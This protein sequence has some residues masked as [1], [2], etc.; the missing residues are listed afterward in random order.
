MSRKVFLISGPPGSGKSTLAKTIA[1]D[2]DK[3]IHIECDSL[4][5]MVQGGHKKPWEEGA[6]TL[7]ALM[8]DVLAAQA[9]IYLQAGFVIISDY[10]WSPQ[11]M[12]SLVNQI[13]PGNLFYPIFLLPK[14]S[15]N[16]ERD[17]NR[18]YTVGSERVSKY[19]ED[20]EKW[21]SK[22]SKMFFDNSTISAIEMSANLIKGKGYNYQE[23]EALFNL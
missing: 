23:I 19:W 1:Q 16:L 7:I 2:F 5:N 18:E 3:S 10:V 12:F 15:I 17:L 20:F 21:Q 8:Y 14:K 4:Y 22:S 9:V 11:E 13:G 6:D